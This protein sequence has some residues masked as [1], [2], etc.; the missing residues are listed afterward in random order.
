MTTTPITQEPWIT[1]SRL[2]AEIAQ[3]SSADGMDIPN[4][5]IQDLLQQAQHVVLMQN[6]PEVM[7]LVEKLNIALESQQ[8]LVKNEIT[9]FNASQQAQNAYRI[10]Q[11]SSTHAS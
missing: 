1:I 8:K 10:K 9:L 11:H 4:S 6:A 7:Q 3:L 2:L 5:N